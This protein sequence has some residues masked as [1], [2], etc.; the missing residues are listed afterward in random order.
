MKYRVILDFIVKNDE[1]IPLD[2][3]T[4]DDVY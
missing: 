4:F 3:E 2:I 1:I